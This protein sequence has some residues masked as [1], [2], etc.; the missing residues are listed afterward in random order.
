M[1]RRVEIALLRRVETDPDWGTFSPL[2]PGEYEGYFYQ[3]RSNLP[4]LDKKVITSVAVRR[5]SHLFS[6]LT[7]L[8]PARSTQ[9][10]F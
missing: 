7:S 5:S 1:L 2:S 10:K 6:T 8:C 4:G 9:D 3:V